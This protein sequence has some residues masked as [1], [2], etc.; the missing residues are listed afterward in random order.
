M[1]QAGQTG[2]GRQRTAEPLTMYR[3]APE[4]RITQ[5]REAGKPAIKGFL[6]LLLVV[7]RLFG[8]TVHKKKWHEGL[9]IIMK[10]QPIT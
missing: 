1:C 5:S 4:P 9:L 6:L 8:P 7:G 10:V 2:G 3:V